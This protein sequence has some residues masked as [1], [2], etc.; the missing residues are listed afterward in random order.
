MLCFVEVKLLTTIDRYVTL[1][2]INFFTTEVLNKNKSINNP[3]H[4]NKYIPITSYKS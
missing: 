4:F 3:I 2:N 1:L